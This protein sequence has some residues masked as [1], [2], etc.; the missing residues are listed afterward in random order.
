MTKFPSGID[1]GYLSEEELG[2]IK[3]MI[4]SGYCSATPLVGDYIATDVPINNNAFN[5]PSWHVSR[6]IMRDGNKYRMDYDDGLTEYIFL[7]FQ[8]PR[9]SMASGCL[10]YGVIL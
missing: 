6:V 7:N 9:I 5:K 10:I 2:L 1:Y 4:D 3:I 8:A